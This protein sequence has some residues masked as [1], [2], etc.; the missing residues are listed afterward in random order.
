MKH[1]L[2]ICLLVIGTVGSAQEFTNLPDKYQEKLARIK[3]DK[4]RLK[5][6]HKYLRKDSTKRSAVL[7]SLKRSAKSQVPG[8]AAIDSTLI[9][10][11][12]NKV[13]SAVMDSLSQ[14]NIEIPTLDST[15]VKGRVNQEV[16]EQINDELGVDVPN[17]SLDSTVSDQAVNRVKQE[18]NTISNEELG[19]D[20]PN[21]PLD[22]TVSDHAANR[23]KQ[24][25]NTI[26]D[27]ELGVDVPSLQLDSAGRAKL[28]KDIE[29]RAGDELKNVEGF[30]QIGDKGELG[31][32]D[33][34]KG[35]LEQTRQQMQQDLAKQR[36]KEKMASQAKEY[37]SKHA[38][39]LQQVQSQM[40]E[41]KKKY[42][43]VP[44]SNDLSTAKKR[45]SLE[46]E[47]LGRRLVFGGNFNVTETNPVS[48]DL[49]PIIGYK[50]NTLFEVGITGLYRAQ[51][52]ADRSGV[53]AEG[54][55]TYGYS[56][57]V[58]HMVFKNFFGYLEGENISR[59]KII[60]DQPIREW[61]QT[62]LLGIGRRFNI[63][64]WLEMQA[65]ITYN[66]LHENQDGVYNSPVVFKTGVRW[67]R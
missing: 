46:D 16:R 7:D 58:N 34:Y 54:E 15:E 67:K 47:P 4:K 31:K 49:S 41:L 2:V 5:K 48:I 65:I 53:Q 10:R 30:D 12:T 1:V 43:Y 56:A 55:H 3:N 6:Y 28:A 45:T 64:K 14:A 8:D 63:A 18:L 27:E 13:K 61:D 17:I 11:G 42:S 19:V 22:S 36:M 9:N 57:F 60:Q 21:I 59:V 66:F 38:D 40:G 44:N 32:L 37:I 26:S 23:V 50:I 39:K 25:L 52:N 24:E 51:F 33:E 20:V 35:Q 29:Q 62:L